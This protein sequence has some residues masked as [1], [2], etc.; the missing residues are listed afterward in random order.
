MDDRLGVSGSVKCVD[1]GRRDSTK[2]STSPFFSTIEPSLTPK[3]GANLAPLP[4]EKNS[5]VIK[6]FLIHVVSIM[7]LLKCIRARFQKENDFG[8]WLK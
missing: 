4:A 6:I 5:K 2:N 8:I 7:V 1:H 3:Q